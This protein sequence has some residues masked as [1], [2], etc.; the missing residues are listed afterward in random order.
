MRI[1][2]RK[3]LMEMPDGTIYH[4]CKPAYFN[5][6]C[7]MRGLSISP[8]DRSC[9]DWYET[10]I[11]SLPCDNEADWFFEMWDNGKSVPI[12]LDGYGREALFDNKLRYA[13][14][15]KADLLGL[16]DIVAKAIAVAKD[17]PAS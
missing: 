16:A 8:Q 5:P 9:V 12:D 11:P 17:S 6:M 1:V 15:E 10:V 7:V 2:T 14:W 4:E 3:E 13:V